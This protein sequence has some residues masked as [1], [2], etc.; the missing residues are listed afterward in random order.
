MDI[1][2]DNMV[3]QM[4]ETMRT[5]DE[6]IAWHKKH[7]EK[8]NKNYIK[9]SYLGQ[10]WSEKYDLHVDQIEK[11][12]KYTNTEVRQNETRNTAITRKP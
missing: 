8:A 4:K 6:K 7:A 9:Y 10:L 12:S 11:L 2:I 5:I 3:V 1:D